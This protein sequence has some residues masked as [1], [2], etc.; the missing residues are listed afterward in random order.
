M[1]EQAMSAIVTFSRNGTALRL[2]APAPAPAPAPDP[3]GIV[4]R[5]GDGLIHRAENTVHGTDPGA[6]DAAGDGTGDGEA[7]C[8]GTTSAVAS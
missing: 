5:D 6:F 8:L 3:A 4:D 1:E 2:L 7:M